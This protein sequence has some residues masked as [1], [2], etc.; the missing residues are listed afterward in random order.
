MWGMSSVQKSFSFGLILTLLRFR[1]DSITPPS[2]L[3]EG[4]SREKNV[5]G[6]ALGRM[7][8]PNNNSVLGSRIH[9]RLLP[10]WEH[11]P[12]Q[13]QQGITGL[14]VA[15]TVSRGCCCDP[16]VRYVRLL[17]PGVYQGIS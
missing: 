4:Y 10:I 9:R 11:M 6:F 3:L 5:L 2:S 7:A 16:A 12:H 15:Y 14:L 1:S 8:H 13:P 17:R